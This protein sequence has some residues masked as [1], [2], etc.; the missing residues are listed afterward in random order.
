ML[1]ACATTPI[2]PAQVPAMPDLEP[3]PA[4]VA[5][6]DAAALAAPHKT[7]DQLVFLGGAVQARLQYAECVYTNGD[8][9]RDRL[10]ASGRRLRDDLIAYQ[11]DAAAWQESY[12]RLDKHLL[13]YYR[14][15]LGEPLADA[16]YQSCDAENSALDTE[17]AE[18]NAA[19]VPLQ[20]RNAQLTA[21]SM[22]YRSDT[23]DM[24]RGSRQAAEDYRQAMEAEATWLGQAYALSISAPMQAYTAKYGCPTVTE[25]PKTAA[26]MLTLGAGVLDC[27]RKIPGEP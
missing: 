5:P 3:C 14:R 10:L 23:A 4:A 27:F 7:L 9:R 15:C 25:P 19:A 22:Q 6:V 18:L 21:E 2:G 1:A 17:R 20:Q 11:R 12:S 8:R 16:Q 26:E 13:D 24:E